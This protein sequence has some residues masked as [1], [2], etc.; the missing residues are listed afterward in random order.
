MRYQKIR[1]FI[2]GTLAIEKLAKKFFGKNY[3]WVHQ[4]QIY[5]FE[6]IMERRIFTPHSP[7]LKKKVFIS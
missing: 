5:I 3:F 1:L 6:I 2:S 7:Y 4:D